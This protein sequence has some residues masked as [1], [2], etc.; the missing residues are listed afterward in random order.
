[1]SAMRRRRA[2]GLVWSLSSMWH[3]APKGFSYQP[4]VND[5][6]SSSSNRL[7]LN[8]ALDQVGAIV[9]KYE[10][11]PSILASLG[12]VSEQRQEWLLDF[13]TEAIRKERQ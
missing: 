5:S 2:S 11:S 10:L 1:M 8:R 13:V 3:S 4:Q 7:L 12:Q 9:C 6:C